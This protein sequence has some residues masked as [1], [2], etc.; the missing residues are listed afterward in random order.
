MQFLVFSGALSLT[1]MATFEADI[2]SYRGICSLIQA[3]I[4]EFDFDHKKYSDLRLG[5][6]WDW[7]AETDGSRAK[8]GKEMSPRERRWAQDS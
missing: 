3:T 1:M 2:I 4:S 5:E 6:Y 7:R 8:E